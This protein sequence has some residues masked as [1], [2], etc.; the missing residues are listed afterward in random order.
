MFEQPGTAQLKNLMNLK[1]LVDFMP[2][3][4]YLYVNHFNQ[5]SSH[6]I[7]VVSRSL[8][9]S[10][11]IIFFHHL[12]PLLQ[13][14]HFFEPPQWFIKE[15]NLNFTPETSQLWW[16]G[17]TDSRGNIDPG[18]RD[19]RDVVNPRWRKRKCAL[20]FSTTWWWSEQGKN[21]ICEVVV[22]NIVIREAVNIALKT[23]V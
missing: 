19:I 7:H 20:A 17:A 15:I 5:I 4:I 13:V 9:S 10:P 14:Y 23:K 22:V 6:C 11:K 12:F 21:L 1:S 16:K 18:C 8:H 2:L 3:L